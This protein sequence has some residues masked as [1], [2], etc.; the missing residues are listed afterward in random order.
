M[1]FFSKIIWGKKKTSYSN[2][3]DLKIGYKEDG[4]NF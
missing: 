2:G 1:E 3:F 4:G